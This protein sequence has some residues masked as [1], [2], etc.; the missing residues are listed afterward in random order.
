MVS[1]G[2]RQDAQSQ[3][4]RMYA[5]GRGVWKDDTEAAKWYR[6][7]ADQYR[8]AANFG[9]EHGQYA[10]GKMHFAGEGV[11]QDYAEDRITCWHICGSI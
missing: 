8:K 6:Q 10:V 5:S 3:L 2:R 1:Q 11:P 4:G 7:A 9:N